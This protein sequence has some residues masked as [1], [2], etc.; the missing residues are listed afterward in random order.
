M[1]ELER[2]RGPA[3]PGSGPRGDPAQTARLNNSQS[4]HA[5]GSSSR[6]VARLRARLG[7]DTSTEFHRAICRSRGIER[8]E[9]VALILIQPAHDF[10]LVIMTN[11][12]GDRAEEP[13]HAVSEEIY[14][15]FEPSK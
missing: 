13:V 10:G 12:G 7:H 4:I 14:G 8:H 2:W 6:Y 11:V 5:A 15:R 3:R 1:G 9:Y